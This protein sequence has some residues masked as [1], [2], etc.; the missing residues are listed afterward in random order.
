MIPPLMILQAFP[1]ANVIFAGIGVLLSVGVL[2]VV[3]LQ[4]ILTPIF[5]R[6]LKMLALAE[7]NS[8]RFLIA[9]KD[10]S[11]GLRST[12]ASHRRRL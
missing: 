4:L 12:L 2:H 1:S 9:S 5:L 7:T 8:S 11:I 10:F 6:Q 3:L